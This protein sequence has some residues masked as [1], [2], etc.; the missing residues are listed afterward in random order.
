MTIAAWITLA[1]STLGLAPALVLFAECAAARPRRARERAPAAGARPSVVVLIP[2]HDEAAT[3]GP[4]LDALRGQLAPRDRV[5][6]VAD[7]CTDGTAEIATR[8]GAEVLERRESTRRGKGFALRSGL[9]ALAAARPDVVVI[10][11]ADCRVAPGALDAL[12]RACAASGRPAQA[13]YRMGGEAGSALARFAFLVRNDVR[14]LG[15][16]RLRL[17]CPLTGTGM[18]FPWPLLDRIRPEEANLVEDLQLGADLARA[19]FAPRFVPDAVVESTLPRGAAAT[20]AQR[21]R[22]EH[23]HL[24]TLGR[25]APRLLATALRTRTLEPL[26]LAADLAVPPLAL[27]ALVQGAALAAATL[28]FAL[29]A[30]ALP[31][32]V[33]A[34]AVA[35][36]AG[37]IALAWT[38]HGR[39]VVSA[40]QLLGA[41]LYA[42]RKV[43]LYVRFLTSRQRDWVRTERD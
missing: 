28:T 9:D 14:P 25:M 37:A 35:V 17:P 15:L 30:G 33:A 16:H 24:A 11:D 41:P 32:V 29:G 23:G 31:L 5:L 13:S 10:V 43:P 19:G 20:R 26:A 38:R 3:L 27:L 1:F 12:A 6:V 21:T 4:T 39:G 40:R 42:L 22:W 7:N 36:F 8:G 18:A 2:A 34:A